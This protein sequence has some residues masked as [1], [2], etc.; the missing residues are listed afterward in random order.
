MNVYFFS[1]IH[2]NSVFIHLSNSR[3][4]NCFLVLIYLQ[5]QKTCPS[6]IHPNGD[7]YTRDLSMKDFL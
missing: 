7:D 4:F 6:G 5:N 1:D 3:Q 2:C